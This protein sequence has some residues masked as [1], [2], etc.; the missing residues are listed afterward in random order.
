MAK[1]ITNRLMKAKIRYPAFFVI[2]VLLFVNA[3]QPGNADPLKKTKWDQ[4][5][6]YNDMTP[7]IGNTHTKTGCVATAVAQIMNYHGHPASGSGRSET[8]T[9]TASGVS[10]P[11]VNFNVRY[12]WNNNLVSYPNATSGTVQERSAVSLLMYQVGVSLGMKYKSSSSSTSI[13]HAPA[14]LTAIFG[15]DKG[16]QYKESRYY[17]DA[18]WEAIIRQQIDAGMPVLYRGA[19]VSN[20]DDDEDDS[21]D[22]SHTF[23][24]DGYD[25]KGQFHVNWGW[26]GSDDGYYSLNAM[27]PRAGRRYNH[28]HRMV[29][30]IKPDKGGSAAGYEMAL[31]EYATSKASVRQNELFTV[32]ARIKNLSTLDEFPG[33]QL[34]AALTD[35]SG[36]IAA[37]IGTINSYNPL[38][39]RFSRNSTINCLIT[40]TVRPGQYRLATVIRPNGG[41]WKVITASSVRDG[42]PNSLNITVSA[43]EAKVDAY[44]IALVEFTPDKTSV[45]KNETFSVSVK[46]R[47]VGT[48]AFPGGQ[49]GVALV[50]NNG[51][52]V[53][54]VRSR[55]YERL[56]SGTTRTST[57]GSC[58]ATAASGRYKLSIVVKPNG[59]EWRVVE[60]SYQGNPTSIDFT[61]R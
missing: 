5:A 25:N 37:V 14:A 22:S 55:D 48:D 20:A 34:G 53:E 17:D 10:V 1:L 58:K 61:V 36:N 29:I 16:I 42:I 28:D 8:Y 23:I 59:G 3:V 51:K 40:E 56:G 4:G 50:D 54:V 43:G 57:I 32:T 49:I 18:A 24:I 52:I 39:P 26:G 13:I 30:N 46:A 11:S 19:S 31:L 15:Y 27:N 38:R 60:L 6:P 33:G 44:G 35:N 12:D 45:P 2:C 9:V 21:E 47:Y 41:N 7:M